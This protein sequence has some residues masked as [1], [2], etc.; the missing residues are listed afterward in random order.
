MSVLKMPKEEV[1]VMLLV[2]WEVS[3]SFDQLWIRRPDA[4]NISYPA[5][6]LRRGPSGAPGRE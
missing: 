1:A 6:I 5:C 4:R 2:D 3:R